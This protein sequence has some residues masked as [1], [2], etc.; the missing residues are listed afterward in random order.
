MMNQKLKI[1]IASFV[2]VI[3]G[4]VGANTAFGATC[5]VTSITDNQLTF[6]A[7]DNTGDAMTVWFY[8]SYP[9]P[10]AGEVW[11]QGYA[12]SVTDGVIT[13]PAGN[14]TRVEVSSADDCVP[15]SGDPVLTGA[16][17]G[18]PACGGVTQGT[19]TTGDVPFTMTAPAGGGGGGSVG[20]SVSDSSDT[21]T[22]L[23]VDIGMTIGGMV[24]SIL[25]L[26]AALLG[27]GWGIRKFRQYVSG[28][29]F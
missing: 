25:A 9:T 14:Y 12:S 23:G 7:S 5:S 6:S 8:T 21:L 15:N 2:F 19:F 22:V 27:L 11:F 28:S 13:L 1:T 3:L 29:K 24:A 18:G 10:V 26:L 17:S 20:F 16:W 4:F